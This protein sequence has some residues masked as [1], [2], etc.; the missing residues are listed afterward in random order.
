MWLFNVNAGKTDLPL[1]D[2]AVSKKKKKKKK[3]KIFFMK[4]FSSVV[5][6]YKGTIQPCMECCHV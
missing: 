1:F 5:V 3:K 4:F 6:L 2:V